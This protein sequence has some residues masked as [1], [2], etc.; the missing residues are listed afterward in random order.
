MVL[1]GGTRLKFMDRT[2]PA[3]SVGREWASLIE[4]SAAWYLA[5]QNLKPS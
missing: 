1:D 2:R 5:R 3:S 4:Y